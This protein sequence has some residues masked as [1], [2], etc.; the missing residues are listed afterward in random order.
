[1]QAPPLRE[2]IR[3]GIISPCSHGDFCRCAQRKQWEAAILEIYRSERQD[4]Q[5]IGMES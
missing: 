3:A 1:M 2:Q 4:E 5:K